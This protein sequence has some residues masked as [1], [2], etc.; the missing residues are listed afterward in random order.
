MGDPA[1]NDY[2]EQP[3]TFGLSAFKPEDLSAELK[4]ATHILYDG[5][6]RLDPRLPMQGFNARIQV[7]REDAQGQWLPC[8]PINFSRSGILIECETPLKEGT[9]VWLDIDTNKGQTG[10]PPFKVGA[11][12]RHTR[13]KDGLRHVGAEFRLGMTANIKRI[14]VEHAIAR[15]EGLLHALNMNQIGDEAPPKAQ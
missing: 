9:L 8:K 6:R 3:S 4:E 12:I 11:V 2:E 5:D 14:Q 15:F 7:A 10:V 13:I 1:M